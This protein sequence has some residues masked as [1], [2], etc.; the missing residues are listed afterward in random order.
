M[1]VLVVVLNWNGVDDTLDCL[2][3]LEQQTHEAFDVLVIDN[4]SA[5]DDVKRLRE[6]VPGVVAEELTI[7]RDEG[8]VGESVSVS[9]ESPHLGARRPRLS[10]H[11]EPE[12][13]GFAGGVNVGIRRALDEAYGAVALLNND[14]IPEP[15]WLSALDAALERTGAAI[16]TGLMVRASDDPVL[17]GTIDT[18]GDALS[19][20]GMPFP[21]GRGRPRAEA[22][23]AGRV[24]SASGG[25]SLFRAELFRDIGLFDATFFA[26]FE[27]VDVGFRARLSGHEIVYDPA[28][29]VHHQVGATSGR[30]PGFTVRQTF[31]NLPLLLV[32]NVPRGLRHRIWPRFGVLFA[33]MLGKAVA[34]GSAKPAL[35]GLGR[36]VRLA[37]THGRRERRRIQGGRVAIAEDLD[38]LLWHDLPPEQHGMRRLLTAP[39]RLVSRVRRR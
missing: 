23:G 12:N 7:D 31:Q 9:R 24:F 18:A 30:I 33:M 27:D 3:A 32:K 35:A 37:A 17:R 6:R 26:Y 4:G 36:G 5:G 21:R 16:A 29:I 10:L 2:D 13:L 22:P 28:A 15:G 1:R 38:A 20:W 19:I 11:E 39:S 8:D 14:A 25:A 34:T